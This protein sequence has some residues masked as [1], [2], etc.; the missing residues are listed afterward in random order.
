M[1]ESTG[2]TQYPTPTFPLFTV[3]EEDTGPLLQELPIYLWEMTKIAGRMISA[4]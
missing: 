4:W 2:L 3:A 1:P